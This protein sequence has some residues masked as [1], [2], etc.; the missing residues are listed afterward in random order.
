MSIK[1]INADVSL[2]WW[3]LYLYWPA[4]KGVLFLARLISEDVC[5]N[6]KRLEF[7]LKKAIKVNYPTRFEPND[8]Q[9]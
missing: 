9:Q 4:T 3:F 5:I 7:W 1:E 2:S 8:N 6:E